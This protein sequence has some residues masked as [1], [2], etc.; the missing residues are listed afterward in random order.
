[1]FKNNW[2][3]L[4]PI[5]KI[6]SELTYFD[7]A[8]TSLKPKK[9]INAINK[10]Y[11]FNGISFKNAG[12][13]SQQVEKLI[14]ETRFLTAAFINASSEEI[15]FTKGTTESL[16]IISNILGKK[17]K[18]NDEIITSELEHNS[19]LFPWI[20]VAQEQKAKIIFIP[21]DKNNRITINNFKKVLSDKTKIV[22][23]NHVSNVLGYETPIESITK[24]AHNK[25][26]L[27]ILDA[28]QSISCKKIDVKK[29]NIDFMAFSAHKMYGPFGVGILFGKKKILKKL[30]PLFVGSLNIKKIFDKKFFFKNLPLKF[31]TG[32]PNISGI[33]AFKE[34]LKLIQKIGFDNIQIHNQI[35]IN[36]IKTEL[37]KINNIEVLNNNN[38]N[39]IILCNSK[40]IH[41][42]DLET[43]LVNNNVYLRTGQYCSDLILKKIKKKNTIRISVGIYNDEKDIANLI[44]SLKEASIFFKNNK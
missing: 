4:F 12:F 38:N 17:I 19:S 1:M 5:F 39:N 24:L 30:D 25:N 27:V 42:H 6:N 18:P 26:A 7:S 23:I 20:K 21:L 8:A 2:K 10:F 22:V 40:Y 41:I 13:L 37:K 32:T 14:K 33:I 3:S 44:R 9:V 15:I 43:F 35:I 16:N 36:K 31:E 28:A 34:S 11:N 29:I